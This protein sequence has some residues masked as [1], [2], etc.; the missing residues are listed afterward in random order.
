MIQRGPA[1]L[2]NDDF[3][4]S[5][6]ALALAVIGSPFCV[7]TVLAGSFTNRDRL[8]LMVETSGYHAMRSFVDRWP[9]PIIRIHLTK[10]TRPAPGPTGER[11]RLCFLRADTDEVLIGHY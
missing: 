10:K 5:K 2:V 6:L 1:R 3:L 8:S 11:A 9:F 7:Q 4:E